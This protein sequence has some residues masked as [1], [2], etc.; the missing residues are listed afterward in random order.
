MGD[1]SSKITLARGIELAEKNSCFKRE[2]DLNKVIF[3]S[4][5]KN[6]SEK[7]EKRRKIHNRMSNVRKKD[8]NCESEIWRGEIPTTRADNHADGPGRGGETESKGKLYCG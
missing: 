2:T 4:E 5:G 6:L 7:N 1:N 8:N 3:H